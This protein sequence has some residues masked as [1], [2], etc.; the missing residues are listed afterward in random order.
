MHLLL[1]AG[2]DNT[3]CTPKINTSL[4]EKGKNK[5]LTLIQDV[6]SNDLLTGKW[7]VIAATDIKAVNQQISVAAQQLQLL[8]NVA[9]VGA[10]A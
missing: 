8:V 3:V 10:L 4:L 7:L 9:L 6:F 1:K 5:Q 2:A